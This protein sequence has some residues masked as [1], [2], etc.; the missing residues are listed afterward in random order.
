[1]RPGQSPVAEKRL[2]SLR[3]KLRG[4]SLF[5]SYKAVMQSL[6]ADGY[7]VRVPQSELTPS[8]G[9]VWY[10]PHHA[11]VTQGHHCV[12]TP[13]KVRVVFD[14]AVRAGGACL[15][16]IL[17]GGLHLGQPLNAVIARF[18]EGRKA[19]TCDIEAMYH[20]V[21]VPARDSD[22]FLFLWFNDDDLSGDVE[23]WHM[24]SHVFG[25]VSSSSVACL[26]VQ[27]C[28]EEG[29]GQFPAAAD[30]LRRR[31]YIADTL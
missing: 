25:S 3:R 4:P 18:R 29:K 20:R 14:C 27:L 9:D 2:M 6:V 31:T 22:L 26:A 8:S 11:V 10:L 23:V 19:L 28:A 24:R 17:R 21:H 7:A 12:T 5:Q 30:A 1:M 15:N 13:S 16:D